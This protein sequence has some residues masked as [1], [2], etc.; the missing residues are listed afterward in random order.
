M[1]HDPFQT[2]SQLGAHP[3][4]AGALGLNPLINPIT[5][6]ISS[7]GPQQVSPVFGGHIPQQLHPLQQLQQ[8]QQ[9]A[10]VMAAAQA[11][12]QPGL[13]PLAMGWHN[14][15]TSIAL[16]HPLLAQSL[17]NPLIN[18][19][20]A[21]QYYQS[22]Y[23]QIGYAGLS[24]FGQAGSPFGQTGY[25]LAPQSWVGQQGSSGV[26]GQGHPL[27]TPFAGRGFQGYGFSPWSAV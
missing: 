21:Q 23:P 19:V 15:W 8:L 12:P 16:Q 22:Q 2:Y 14:P 3:A 10:A 5:A 9:L 26:F 7:L 11:S 25:P 20:L 17:Y 18:P 13:S 27:Q 6:G 1:M 4:M 24:P